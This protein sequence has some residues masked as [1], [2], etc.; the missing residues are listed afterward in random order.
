MYIHT[1]I[2]LYRGLRITRSVMY[3]HRDAQSVRHGV[4]LATPDVLASRDV[5][6]PLSHVSH[7]VVH[8]TLCSRE[9]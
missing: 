4:R 5:V 1:L 6:D 7:H 9:Y 8:H 2:L 3:L